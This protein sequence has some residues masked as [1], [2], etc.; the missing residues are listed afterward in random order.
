[1]L[2]EMVLSFILAGLCF[3]C[4]SREWVKEHSRDEITRLEAALGDSVKAQGQLKNSQEVL[5]GQVRDLYD[6][7]KAMDKRFVTWQE[8]LGKVKGDVLEKENL[9]LKEAEKLHAMRLE[10]ENELKKLARIEKD[11]NDIKESLQHSARKTDIVALNNAI[12]DT[13]RYFNLHFTELHKAHERIKDFIIEEV[14]TLRVDYQDYARELTRLKSRLD[15]LEKSTG[16]E[17]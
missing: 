15:A 17:S 5:E 14:R 16:K 13:E 7:L 8:T 9:F 12:S 1:M 11:L 4:A 3:G 10:I 2:R 6:T